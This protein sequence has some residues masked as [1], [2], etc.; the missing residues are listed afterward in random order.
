MRVGWREFEPYNWVVECAVRY[1]LVSK[2]NEN[3]GWAPE[4]FAS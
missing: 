1:E 3:V 2:I 4:Y